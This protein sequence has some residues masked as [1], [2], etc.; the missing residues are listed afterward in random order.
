MPGRLSPLRRL[1]DRRRLP[2]GNAWGVGVDDMPVSERVPA[3]AEVRSH[4]HQGLSQ[5]GAHDE[6][7]PSLFQQ[8]RR[9]QHPGIRDDDEVCQAVSGLEVGDH[10]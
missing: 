10:R 7:Q 9:G 2:R 4:V 1:V 6:P 8:V 3:P 5:P